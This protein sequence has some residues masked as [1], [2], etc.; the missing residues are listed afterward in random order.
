[1]R[2]HSRAGA[3]SSRA[4][5]CASS[6]HREMM[7]L[8]AQNGGRAEAL[9]HYARCAELLRRELSIEPMPATR[10]LYEE[11]RAQQAQD[12]QVST[13]AEPELRVTDAQLFLATAIDDLAKALKQVRLAAARVANPALDLPKPP[14][15]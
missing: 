5:R 15:L 8:Y 13:S 7:R 6:V 14:A 10:A 9:R 12:S 4:N 1:M 11:I 2:R 3:A